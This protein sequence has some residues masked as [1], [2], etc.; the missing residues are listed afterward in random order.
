MEPRSKLPNEFLLIFL[1]FVGAV[2]ASVVAVTYGQDGRKHQTVLVTLRQLHVDQ[3]S[4]Q[5]DILQ[6]RAGLLK[7]YDPLVQSIVGLHR[8]TTE[9]GRLI[10]QID[11]GPTDGELERRIREL[12]GQIGAEE[13]FV[14]EFKTQNALLGNSYKLFAHLLAVSDQDGAPGNADT[15]DFDRLASLMLRYGDDPRPEFMTEL[16]ARFAALERS[17]DAAAHALA[18]HGRVILTARPLVDAALDAVQRSPVPAMI[19][20]IE[21]SYVDAY[22][23]ANRFANQA[24]LVLTAIALALC[25]L[26]AVLLGRLRT[27]SEKLAGQLAFETAAGLAKAWLA[28]SDSDRFDEAARGALGIFSE[29]LSADGTV[30]TVVDARSGERREQYAQYSGDGMRHEAITA[31]IL[32]EITREDAPEQP[33]S[34]VADGENPVRGQVAVARFMA[35]QSTARPAAFLILSCDMP[36]LARAGAHAAHLRAAL[37]IFADAIRLNWTRRDR[38]ALEQRLEHA[39]RLEAVGTLAGGVA[40][41]FNNCLGAILGYGELMLKSARRQSAA[42]RYAREIVATC[43]RAATIID[44]ILSFSRKRQRENGAF[45]LTEVV[46][47]SIRDARAMLPEEGRIDFNPAPDPLVISGHPVE[48]QQIVA[49]L[50]KNAVEAMGPAADGAPAGRVTVTL[51]RYETRRETQL[52]HGVLQPGAYAR[53]T[54]ADEGPGISAHARDHLFEPFFTTKGSHGGTGLGLAVVHGSVGALSGQIEVATAMGRGTRFSIYLP[55]SCAEPK[56]LSAFFEGAP[57]PRGSGELIAILDADRSRRLDYEDRAAAFGYEPV[58]FGAPAEL[59]AWT[60]TNGAADLVVADIETCD[61]VTLARWRAAFGDIPVIVIAEGDEPRAGA[62]SGPLGQQAF[63]DLLARALG[64]GLA[65]LAGSVAVP[66][67][68]S[69]R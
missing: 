25:G 50:C 10:A 29:I 41:E 51:E 8:D 17:P 63:A 5:R 46:R 69:A 68:G 37:D 60:K 9:L 20:Q 2:V 6:I 21:R 38:T 49:N 12:Q 40:H 31:L 61:P 26:V 65:G 34:V 32:A 23:Y 14:E 48:V 64:R 59:A 4:L 67:E 1:F 44:Q 24:K 16:T 47:A 30:L 58:G 36:V 15:P 33:F 35:G 18:R 54:V 66:E 13:G 56:P 22:V 7:N 27:R 3:A 43:H 53:L 28:D 62:I 11:L 55:L 57:V 39:K 52:S 42:A 45:D 19:E